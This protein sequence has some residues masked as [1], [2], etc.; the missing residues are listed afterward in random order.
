V[1]E[2]AR[3]RSRRERSLLISGFTLVELL[4]VIAV[5]GVIIGILL[6]VLSGSRQRA[7]DV[8][9]LGNHRQF[10]VAFSTYFADF[11][12]FVYYESPGGSYYDPILVWGGANWYEGVEDDVPR[13]VASHRPINPYMG[14]SKEHNQGF[15]VYEC[16]RDNGIR[17]ARTDELVVWMTD[18]GELTRA[19]DGPVNIYSVLGTSYRANDWQYCVPGSEKGI[20][21]PP[22][23][24]PNHRANQGPDDVRTTPSRFVLVCDTGQ[25]RAGRYDQR[26]REAYNIIT[27]WWHGY[28]VG[29][30]LF[31]DG[32]ARR[33]EMGDITTPTYT[34]YMDPDAHG[35][36]SYR[37]FD[38]P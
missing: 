4:V 32:S 26:R 34:F 5:I 18:W 9:C 17:Y 14:L 20:G 38:R 15:G 16:P 2:D 33:E 24:G 25:D 21:G 19:P 29:N 37:R 31:L 7:G 8:A 13:W 10:G 6:P 35:P 36:G 23:P 12:N 27:G 22:M 3:R 30:M 11:D 1:T 28:E